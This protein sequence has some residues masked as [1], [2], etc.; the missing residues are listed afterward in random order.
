VDQLRLPDPASAAPADLERPQASQVVAALETAWAAIAGRHPE[1]PAAVVVIGAGSDR[2]QGLWK[3][4]HFAALRWRHGERA[5]PEVLVAGEGLRRPAREVLETLLHEAGH[6]LADVRGV[7]DTSRGG[8]Y[9]N[10]RY[11]SLALEVG[12]EVREHRPYGWAETD[13][14]PETERAYAGELEGLA[15]ALVVHRVAERP[16]GRR[17]GGEDGDG[18]GDQAQGGDRSRNLRPAV[19]GCPRPRRLRI[20]ASTLAAGPIV[21]GLCGQPFT[22]ATAAG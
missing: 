10:R 12:L 16:A 13:L 21:C 3:W 6:G 11:R 1:L 9:H 2:R 14:L 20:A 17:G 8:R 15:A 18:D 19:C 4:G 5:L 22:L 7:D